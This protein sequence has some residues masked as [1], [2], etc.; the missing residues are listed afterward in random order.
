MSGISGQI[1]G[2]SQQAMNWGTLGQIGGGLFDAAGGFGTLFQS[3]NAPQTPDYFP[4]KK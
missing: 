2:Y 4:A 3:P 1:S